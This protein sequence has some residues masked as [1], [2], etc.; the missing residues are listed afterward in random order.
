MRDYELVLVL[1]PDLTTERQKKLISKIKKMVAD[2][3]GKVGK[4]DEWGKKK[5]AYPIAKKT[6][7]HYFFMALSLPS[8]APVEI[9]KNFRIEEDL[10]R[11]LL[12]RSEK[13]AK[14]TGKTAK[15]PKGN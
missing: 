11:Y 2:L 14:K 12:I 6:S 4:T 8:Q 5:L 9:E 7:G 13:P 3:K 10:L 15:S 1:D